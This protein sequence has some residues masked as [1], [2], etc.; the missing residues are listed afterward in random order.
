MSVYYI[1]C[2]CLECGWIDGFRADVLN[3]RVLAGA[4]T[5]EGFCDDCECE[6]LFSVVKEGCNQLSLMP[7]EKSEKGD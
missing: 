4:G 5:V 7:C 1:L 6:R 3:E 2:R